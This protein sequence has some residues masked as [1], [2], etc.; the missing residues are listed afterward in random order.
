[1]IAM[2]VLKAPAIGHEATIY[3]A[4]TPELRSVARQKATFQR[5]VRLWFAIKGA[6]ME[7]F[8]PIGHF[9][10]ALRSHTAPLCPS[11]TSEQ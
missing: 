7:F 9:S 11:L 3:L 8:L 6:R 2:S 1:M 10:E 4:P 5:D